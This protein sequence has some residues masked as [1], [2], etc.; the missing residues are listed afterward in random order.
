QAVLFAEEIGFRRITV[1]GDALT[2]IKKVISK[3]EDKSVL[4]T[5]G[6]RFETVRYWIEEAPVRVE[7]LVTEDRR[8]MQRGGNGGLME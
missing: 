1:E 6:K 3:D 5:E 8:R 2:I 7:K 4:S